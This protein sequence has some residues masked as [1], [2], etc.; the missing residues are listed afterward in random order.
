MGDRDAHVGCPQLRDHRTIGEFD[1]AVDDRLRVHQNVDLIRRQRKQIRGFNDFETLVHHRRRIDGDL[2]SHA[3]VR[4]FQGLRKRRLLD[5][6][7]GPGPE[8]PARGGDDDA[9]QLF[10]IAGTQRLKQC[11]M[12]GIRGQDAGAGRGG[13]LHEEITCANKAFLVRKR[14]RRAPIHGRE[15]GLQSGSTADGGHDPVRRAGC[16]FNDGAFT[17]AAFGAGAGQGLFQLGKA[18]GIGDRHE[19][20][21]KFP[22]QLG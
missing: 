13:A 17:G 5:I 12:L 20:R 7:N 14:N 22:R 1:H 2:L 18:V 16:G 21:A 10:P 15:R 8:R 9:K 3:P 19:S 6:G 4:V 11:V